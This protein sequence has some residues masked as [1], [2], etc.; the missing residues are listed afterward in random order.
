M[1]L[2]QATRYNAR[3]P[4]RSFV[5]KMGA[6]APRVVMALSA[7]VFTAAAWLA[8]RR[9]ERVA[10]AGPSMEP[11][12][13]A[14]DHLVI[15]KTATVRPGDIVAATDPRQPGRPILK[16]ALSVHDGQVFLVGDNAEHSTDS[17]HF[18]PVPLSSVVGKAVYRYAPA[19]RTGRLRAR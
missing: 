1:G 5:A 16:R 10:V 6:G 11:G 9:F 8:W 4:N 14:G 7:G 2:G 19:S 17:R 3:R 12:L 13:R 18:G 15:R